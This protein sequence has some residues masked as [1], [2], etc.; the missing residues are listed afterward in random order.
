[1]CMNVLQKLWTERALAIVRAP[2]RDQA[3][4][5]MEAAV[6]AGFRVCEFT[7]NTPGALD[8]VRTFSRVS[9]L[10]VGVGTALTVEDVEQGVAA[11]AQFVVSPVVDP[12]VIA[13]ALQLGVVP[14]PGCA[15]P[16]EMWLAHR[17]GAPLQKIFPSPPGAAGPE[18][19]RTVRGPMPFLRLVPTSGVDLHNAAGLL[20]AGAFAVGFVRTLFE[21]QWLEARDRAPITAR[22]RQCLEVVRGVTRG[23]APP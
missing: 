7:L 2:A 8:L 6:E 13:R 17:S 14:I 18:Y 5:A 10:C 19:V 15:T 11:G 22:A 4:V 1:M 3:E 9:D 16:T 20:G 23:V 12:A 21:P